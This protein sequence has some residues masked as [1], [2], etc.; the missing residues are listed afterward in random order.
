MSEKEIKI[1]SE[2]Q[3]LIYK[4]ILDLINEGADVNQMKVGEVT[5]RAG[6][7]KGTAY[8][9]FTSKEEMVK[10]AL[11]YNTYVQIETVKA[12][13]IASESFREKFLCIL[14]YMEANKGEIRTFLWLMRLQGKDVDIA[15]LEP[16]GL[17]CEETMAKLGYIAELAVWFL[18]YGEE[19]GLFTQKNKDYQISALIAQI[20]QFGFYLHFGTGQNLEEVKEFIYEGLIKQLS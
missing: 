6:I 11:E 9:Y 5:A 2:K 10:A 12:M 16:D 1:P 3:I 7:G 17:Q 15:S 4:A 19:E 8:E 13:V 14:N 20:V 18:A